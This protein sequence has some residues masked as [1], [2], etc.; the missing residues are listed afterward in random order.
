M[1]E[2]YKNRS[3]NEPFKTPYKVE[4]VSRKNPAGENIKR[5][6]MHGGGV[7]FKTPPLCRSLSFMPA[8]TYFSG[9]SCKYL[10][11]HYR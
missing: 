5:P 11:N 7:I 3:L 10:R 9:L 8:R 1:E 4:I 2:M 6:A